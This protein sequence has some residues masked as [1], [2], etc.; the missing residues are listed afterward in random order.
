MTERDK[1]EFL[2]IYEQSQSL[3]EALEKFRVSDYA[4]REERRTDAV[5]DYKFKEVAR[6]HKPPRKR[7]RKVYRDKKEIARNNELKELRR[8]IAEAENE[9]KRIANRLDTDGYIQARRTL[10]LMKQKYESLSVKHIGDGATVY[11]INITNK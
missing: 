8:R 6:I 4:V 9:C 3:A 1:R 5:F 7:E 2:R 10:D 11:H